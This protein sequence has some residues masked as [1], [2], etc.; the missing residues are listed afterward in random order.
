MALPHLSQKQMLVK[1]V[2]PLTTRDGM[3]LGF[4]DFRCHC[5][6]SEVSL[7]IRGEIATVI[8]SLFASFL[9][10]RATVEL[11]LADIR[12]TSEDVV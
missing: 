7:S 6:A 2:G 8:T 1:S 11:I 9:F 12:L 10:L 5:T 4:L 3:T